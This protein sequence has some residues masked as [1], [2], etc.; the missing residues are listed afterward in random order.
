MFY[1]YFYRTI[2]H[3]ICTFN[4]PTEYNALGQEHIIDDEDKMKI[5]VDPMKMSLDGIEISQLEEIVEGWMKYIS[6]ILRESSEK[7]K[8]REF[9]NK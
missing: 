3:V 2:D 8:Y 7:V 5:K 1:L 4:L 9:K 6:K